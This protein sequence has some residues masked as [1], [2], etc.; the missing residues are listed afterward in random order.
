MTDTI[1]IDKRTALALQQRYYQAIEAGETQ[2]VFEDRDILTSYAKYMIEY[3][4]TQ[5]LLDKETK[6]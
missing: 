2:F 5:G 6:H 3:L 4:K 1:H